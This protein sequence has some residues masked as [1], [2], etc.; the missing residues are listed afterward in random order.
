MGRGCCCTVGGGDRRIMGHRANFV[1]IKDGQAKA[2]YDNWAA[3][4]CTLSLE[5]GAKKLE[6][7]VPKLYEP[8]EEL[9]DWGFAE[10]GFLI[11]YDERICIAFGI[12]EIDMSDI[13]EDHQEDI[14]M[15][16]DAF[17]AGW[18]DFVHFIEHGWRG[19]TMIW[20]RRGVDAFAVHL[21]R[22]KITSIK[23]AKPSHPK[24]MAKA[25]PD[26]VEVPELGAKRKTTKKNAP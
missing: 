16:L 17:D 7:S 19:F 10:A 3:L 26:V 15:T 22:R 12:P 8:T 2:F 23:T 20:D 11:D 13:P 6:K 4:G 21:E 24:Y 25:A 1:L 14:G 5:E 9:L 18:S